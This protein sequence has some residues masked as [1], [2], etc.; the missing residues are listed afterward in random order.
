M[1]YIKRISF[2]ISVRP[3]WTSSCSSTQLKCAMPELSVHKRHIFVKVIRE[4]SSLLVD[5]HVSH[6][7]NEWSRS[8]VNKCSLCLAQVIHNTVQPKR[9]SEDMYNVRELRR[10]VRTKMDRS[11]PSSRKNA[12]WN[13]AEMNFKS[14]IN[15]DN[16]DARSRIVCQRRRR[17]RWHERPITK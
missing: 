9:E 11:V 8:K 12:L 17:Q 5:R 6:R 15:A 13:Q 14:S 10:S 7:K 1:P 3:S 4:E 2:C 16:Y